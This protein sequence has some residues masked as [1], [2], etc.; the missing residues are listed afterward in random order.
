MAPDFCRI[1]QTSK[2]ARRKGAFSAGFGNAMR[3]LHSLLIPEPVSRKDTRISGGFAAMSYRPHE[4]GKWFHDHPH[5]RS[6]PSWCGGRVPRVTH[7]NNPEEEGRLNNRKGARRCFRAPRGLPIL[8]WLRRKPRVYQGVIQGRGHT[9]SR[10]MAR[11]G[12]EHSA[13]FSF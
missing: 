3:P 12:G 2:C 6:Q 10:P 4:K 5:Q 9:N 13:S 1:F 8:R 7:S 11:W